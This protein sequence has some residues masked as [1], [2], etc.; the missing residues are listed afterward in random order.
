M[1]PGDH[2]R[3]VHRRGRQ[4]GTAVG[5]AGEQRAQVP[6]PRHHRAVG[7]HRRLLGPALEGTDGHRLGVRRVEHVDARRIHATGERALQVE[8]L[9]GRHLGHQVRHALGRQRRAQPGAPPRMVHVFDVVHPVPLGAG[10]HVV[11]VD[12][13][14]VHVLAHPGAGVGQHTRVDHHP[15]QLPRHAQQVVEQRHPAR[16][17]LVD[18]CGRGGEAR[19]HLRVGEVVEVEPPTHGRRIARCV[20]LGG[21]RHLGERAVARA[22][23]RVQR[24]DGAVVR[25]QPHLPPSNVGHIGAHRGGRAVV[26]VHQHP[27]ARCLV[28][29][30]PGPQRVAGERLEG[31]GHSPQ[32]LRS[33][34][35][36]LGRVVRQA[37]IVRVAVA[38]GA[39]VEALRPPLGMRVDQPGGH[40]TAQHLGVAERPRLGDEPQPCPP[41]AFHEAHQVAARVGAAV[42]V[43]LP[44]DGFVVEPRDI[45][46]HGVGTRLAG[47]QQHQLPPLGRH[48]VVVDLDGAQRVGGQRSMSHVSL[49]SR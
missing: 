11:G 5:E 47:P 7:Q 38:H 6:P 49:S 12:V 41:A 44:V 8:R 4:V 3:S 24:V 30:L 48:A 39:T 13:F 40:A 35:L 14:G 33:T 23:R 22:P 9:A 42:E 45:A 18:R 1:V 29:D 26:L 21:E 10:D 15:R 25:G 34:R 2:H 36:H 43:D 20:P 28:V 19:G 37:R 17:H 27:V 16:Q 31:H 46:R 32:P